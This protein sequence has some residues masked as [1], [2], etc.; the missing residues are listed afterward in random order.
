VAVAV[1]VGRA[2]QRL[3]VAV[4][5]AVAPVAPVAAVAAVE[6]RQPKR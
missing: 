4:A 1:P 2:H 3:P 6:I 5:V